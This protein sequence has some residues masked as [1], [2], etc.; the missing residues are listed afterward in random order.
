[1]KI[2]I[3][4]IELPRAALLLLPVLPVMKHESNVRCTYIFSKIKGVMT[5]FLYKKISKMISD[6]IKNRVLQPGDRIPSQRQL[7]QQ[8]KVSIGTIQHAYTDLEDQGLILPK[9]RSGYYVRDFKPVSVFSQKP[10]SFTPAPSKITVLET[11]IS[12]MRSA[13]RKD[14]VQLGSAVPNVQGKAVVQL[15]QALKR[16]AHKIPNYEEDPQGYLPLRRQLARRSYNTG[17]PLHPNGI[18]IT[19]GC[20]EALTIALRCI[21]KPGDVIAV[22][23]PCYYGALQAMELLELKTIE[24]PT[25]PVDGIDTEILKATLNNWPVKG[26]LLNPS[27]SNPSGYLCSDSKKQEIIKLISEKDIPLIE[28]DI[29]ADLGFSG[30]RPRTIQSYDPDGRVILCSSISKTICP[31]LRIGWMIPGRYTEKAK[32]LKFISTLCAPC[33]PQFALADFLSNSAFERHI[34]SMASTYREKQQ[35]L[36]AAIKNRLPNETKV[37]QPQGGFLCWLKLPDKIDGFTLYQHCIKEGI[38]LTPGEICSPT[39]Q[40]KNYIR[41]N[42]AIASTDE[43]D[44]SMKVIA[45]LVKARNL[46]FATNQ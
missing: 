19:A 1:M 11:A 40:F 31:D 35:I 12:V 24:I 29:F 9:K 4:Q 7:S 10:E 23:S 3:V 20:Q 27:F 28:D 13:A 22:E 6:Q 37:T 33:H 46:D 21:A 32:K 43:I 14:L 16:H 18:V 44:F 30:D 17:A 38:S 8:L 5:T 2:D 45:K 34:R 26:I 25:S 41:L 15:H 42:Y 36:L 39:G